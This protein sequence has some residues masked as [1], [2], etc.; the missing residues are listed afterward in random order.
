MFSVQKELQKQNVDYG[1]KLLMN[2]RDKY[3]KWQF[4]T[5]R[6]INGQIGSIYYMKHEYIKAKPYL[7]MSFSKHWIAQG[8]LAILYF[9]K[10]QYIKMNII[11]ERA[12]K[13]SSKQGLLWSVW[14][15]CLF[16]AGKNEEAIKILLRAQKKVGNA[17][18]RIQQNLIN[19]QNK[20]KI[21]MKSYGEQ[22]YQ[23]NLESLSKLNYKK[24]STVKFYKH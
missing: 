16:R 15:Y 4:F 5:K 2:I 1:I 3:S 14:A 18:Y 6:M 22:W 17:D 20:K 7:E 12:V 10:K 23:F 13:Y 19:L 24:G 21:K 11:F 8:M 9:K